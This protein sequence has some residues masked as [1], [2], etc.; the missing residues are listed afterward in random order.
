MAEIRSPRRRASASAISCRVSRRRAGGV[1]PHGERRAA[2]AMASNSAADPTAGVR[3]V[4]PSRER[5][6]SAHSRLPAT[7]GSVSGSLA[8]TPRLREYAD[9][10]GRA[11]RR[12]GRSETECRSRT[13]ARKAS[14]WRRNSSV[15]GAR[16]NMERRKFPSAEFS[17][18]RR[19][20]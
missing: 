6:P 15:F 13:A 9:E 4:P 19:K 7:A 12:R 16:V 18:S 3:T 1:F 8:K 2:S 14:A 20:R 17:S 11:G 10:A 5:T